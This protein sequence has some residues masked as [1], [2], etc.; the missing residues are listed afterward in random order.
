MPSSW[1]A[2]SIP[3]SSA[4]ASCSTASPTASSPRRSRRSAATAGRADG[5]RLA[6]RIL[7]CNYEYPPLGGGGGVINAMLAEALAQRHEVTILTSRA[8]GCP[9]DALQHGVRVVR[10][11]VLARRQMAT[12][13]IPSMFAY[14]VMGML[15]GRRM[16]AGDRFG[17][18]DTYL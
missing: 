9:L 8:F 15:R 6:M 3:R 2:P 16:V 11:P 17:L 18:V 10:V 1:S 5:L 4:S 7:F 13:N 14:L 12:A